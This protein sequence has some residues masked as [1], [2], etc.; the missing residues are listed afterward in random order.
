MDCSRNNFC[1]T[2]PDES[3]QKLC[4]KCRRRL[5]KAH[6]MQMLDD[7]N[8]SCMLI[9]DGALVTT[10]DLGQTSLDHESELPVLY[11]GL[12]GRL[13]NLDITFKYEE[14]VSS[15]MYVNYHYLAD[16]WVATFSHH[17]IRELCDADEEFRHAVYRNMT[18]LMR[19]LCQTTA[20]FRSNYLHFGVRHLVQM[21][22]GAGVF[23]TQQQIADVMNR[24][25]T[26]VSKAFT[27]LK[28]EHPDIWKAYQAN[29]GRVPTTPYPGVE[30]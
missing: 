18:A 1:S 24:D 30:D 7:V 28:K 3:R 6:S 26:S 27:Q 10:T 21:L 20:L 11:L 16:T 5:F 25:R 12:P 22:V 23:L 2:L 9:L 19:D 8:Q 29:K 14:L 13:L 17:V 4:A 15:L